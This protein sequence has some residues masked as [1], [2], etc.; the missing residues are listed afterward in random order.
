MIAAGGITGGVDHAIKHRASAPSHSKRR[1]EPLQLD[2]CIGGVELPVCFC[3]VFVAL[4]APC[5]DFLGQGVL[6][7]MR[8][9]RHWLDSTLSSL[10]AMSSQL[11]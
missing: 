8:R 4:V 9:S 3:V 2:A 6:V 11:L 5:G 10:S 7:G 1:V